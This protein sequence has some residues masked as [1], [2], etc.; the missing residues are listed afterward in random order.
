MLQWWFFNKNHTIVHTFELERSY[1]FLKQRHYSGIGRHKPF[2]WFYAIV[3]TWIVMR[4]IHI[5]NINLS[6]HNDLSLIAMS[7]GSSLPNRYWM[8]TMFH[9]F[10]HCSVR[11]FQSVGLNKY[12]KWPLDK[13]NNWSLL[14]LKKWLPSNLK[15]FNSYEIWQNPYELGYS[16]ATRSISK[17]PSLTLER[18]SGSLYIICI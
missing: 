5:R 14:H 4:S 10:F 16:F 1:K 13:K 3:R 11:P 12:P 18:P 7:I 9:C 15:R 2:V 8:F 17:L 6:N